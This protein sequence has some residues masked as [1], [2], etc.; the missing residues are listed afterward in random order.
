MTYFS[1][2]DSEVKVPS[3]VFIMTVNCNGQSRVLEFSNGIPSNNTTTTQ[4]C[5]ELVLVTARFVY[6][7]YIALSDIAHKRK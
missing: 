7:A 6:K 1:Q 3:K 4:V 5:N 2:S